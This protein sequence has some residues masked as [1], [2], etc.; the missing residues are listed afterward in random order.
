MVSAGT[1][2][3]KKRLRQRFGIRAPRVTVR[4]HVPWYFFGGAAAIGLLLFMGLG[5]WVYDSGRRFAG[6]DSGASAQEIS[7]LRASQSELLAE[8]ARLRQIAD[9]GESKFQ[10]EHTTGQ[11]LAKQVKVLEMENSSLREDLA[12]F[13]GLVPSGDATKDSGPKISRFRIEPDLAAGQYRYRML[14]VQRGGKGQ[15]VFHGALELV[16]KLQ[17]GGKDAMIVLPSGVEEAPSRFKLE[18]KYF[19]RVEGVFAIPTGAVVKSVE[20]RLLQNGSIFSRQ[21]LN[22]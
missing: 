10:I 18:I 11:Q 8:V 13:E 9:T 22:L 16:V 12:F 6:F 14:I 2:L 15:P 17:Q 7:R 20:A 4:A 1:S 3:I 5:A 21:V 19:Q